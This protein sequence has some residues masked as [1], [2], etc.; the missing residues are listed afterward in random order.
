MIR[1]IYLLALC[2]AIQSCSPKT[3]EKGSSS[4]ATDSLS[5]IENVDAAAF[6]AKVESGNGIILDVRTPEEV[7]QGY[8]KNATILNIYDPNFITEINKL[9]KEKEVYVYCASGVRSVQAAKILEKNGFNHIYNM[10][11]GLMDWIRKGYPL[12]K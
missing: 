1:I 5:T 11:A 12:V 7:A 9:P 10:K 8:I 4:E 6:K 2:I 3:E